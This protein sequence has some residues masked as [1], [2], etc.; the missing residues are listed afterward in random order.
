MKLSLA[1]VATALLFTL[2]SSP[3]AV[4]LADFTEFDN[5]GAYDSPLFFGSWEGQGVQEI[6]GYAISGVAA[7][8]GN[9]SGV[10][11]Y[12]PEAVDFTGQQSLSV[13]AKLLSGNESEF[14]VFQLADSNGL[15]AFAT[16]NTSW[17]VEGG[18][19]TVVV[20]FVVASGFDFSSVEQWTLTGGVPSGTD[21]VALSIQ[22]AAAVPEPNAVA[23]LVGAALFVLLRR[24]RLAP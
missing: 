24:R 11:F 16:F 22:S 14:F 15:Y 1:A 4:V 20:P 23:L 13:G 12:F 17:F 6:D 3:A 9:D 5:S 21:R 2:S 10:D 19:T 18:F 7:E 8:N